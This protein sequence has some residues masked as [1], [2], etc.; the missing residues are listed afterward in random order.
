MTHHRRH[1]AGCLGMLVAI[2]L[3]TTAALGAQSPAPSSVP[4]PEQTTPGGGGPQEDLSAQATDPTASLMSFSFLSDFTL[5]Y[6]DLDESGFEF[7]FQ[8][9]VPFRAWKTN[10]ILR[11]VVPYQ[12]SGWALSSGDLQ[13]T[14]DWQRGEWVSVPIGVQI[15]VVRR[16]AGQAF[17][18]SVNPQW[19]LSDIAGAD[20]ATIVLG[21]TLLAPAG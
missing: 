15:G 11:V 8:P 13:F 12:A 4:K 3:S 2:G 9:V 19:N 10:N 7:R 21:I 20:K 5:S 1:L 6:H 16:I 17:R 14:Y 18:V